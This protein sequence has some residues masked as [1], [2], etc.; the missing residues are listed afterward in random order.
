MDG[1][2][3]TPGDGQPIDLG[4]ITVHKLLDGIAGFPARTFELTVQ[5]GFDV[6]AHTHHTGV[7]MFY[8]LDG[9]VDVFGF[10]P[11]SLE[12][13]WQ[14]WVSERSEGV[15]QAGPGSLLIVPAGC[16]HAFANRRP[17][18]ARLLFQSTVAGQE[19]YFIHLAELLRAGEIDQQA[20]AELRARYD[21]E[22]ITPIRADAATPDSDA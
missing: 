21:T 11:R 9:E 6:G 8:V 20:V 12:G 3:H 22:A 2:V 10:H 16:P 18:P 19:E 1:H 14:D 4:R 5:Q 13:P 17:S 7:E 15:R